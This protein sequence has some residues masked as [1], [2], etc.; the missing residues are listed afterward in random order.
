MN[1][2]AFVLAVGV[3]SPSV[4]AD[5]AWDN[6][7]GDSGLFTWANGS[8]ENGHMRDPILS[9]DADTFTFSPSLDH[10]S[11]N[12]GSGGPETDAASVDLHMRAGEVFSRFT[13]LALFQYGIVESGTVQVGIELDY[14]DLLNPERHGRFIGLSELY[15]SGITGELDHEGVYFDGFLPAGLAM[16]DV[17]ITARCRLMTSVGAGVDPRAWVYLNQFYVVAPTP[18]TLAVG[19]G[20]LAVAGRRRR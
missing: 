6:S 11:N 14:T 9:F 7:A 1:I 17:R 19:F 20:V 5:V 8:N 18:G 16:T 15:T 3:V 2:R 4:L 12:G 13:V 10:F